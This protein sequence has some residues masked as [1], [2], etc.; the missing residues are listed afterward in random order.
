MRYPEGGEALRSVDLHVPPRQMVFIT[1]HSG[2]G[3]S[4]M[5]R[6]ITLMERCS[7]GQVV[8]GGH[9]LSRMRARHVPLYRRHLGVVFQDHRLL[10]ERTVFDNVALPLIAAGY[11]HGEVRRRVRAALD[12]VGLLG[13]E[14]LRP[15]FLSS[16]EQQRVGIA[17]A[18]VHRPL[19]LLAD[20]PTGNLDPDL[21][22]DTMALFERF[23]QIGGTVLVATHDLALA[24]SMSHRIITLGKGMIVDD[25]DPGGE[26]E[27]APERDRLGLT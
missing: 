11:R 9:N 18:V 7:R 19:L 27:V 25:T 14:R 13:K 12:I 2:A 15:V 23:N 8:V 26:R 16:G 5:L 22:R 20:E 10:S 3:K 17:R 24:R 1:G 21:S 6:L 4:T